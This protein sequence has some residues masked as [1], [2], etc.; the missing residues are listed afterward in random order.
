MSDDK[1]RQALAVNA[2]RKINAARRALMDNG[3]GMDAK[4]PASWCEFGYKDQLSFADY[5]QAYD[6]TALGFAAVDKRVN[7]VWSDYPWIIEGEPTD[8]DRK[9]S[10][11]EKRI[12]K[13]AKRA[14]L[15][16]SLKRAD[17]MRMIGGW[18]ALVLRI[19]DGNKLD[20]AVQTR[21]L[22][23]DSLIEV[24]PVYASQ[25]Q[26]LAN[27]QGQVTKYQYSKPGT[28]IE[29]ASITDIHPDRVII[30]GDPDNDRSLLRSGYNNL[31]DIEKVSGGSGE[32]F[33]KN[34]ARAIGINFDNDVEFEDIARMYGKKPEEMHEVLN[35]VARDMN[36][37]IDTVLATQGAQVQTLTSPVS[38][39]KPTFEVASQMF[40]ASVDTP[41]KILIGNVTGERAS[42]EDNA[43]WNVTCQAWRTNEASDL[44]K[45]V[46]DRL[47]DFGALTKLGEYSVMWTDLR[48]SSPTERAEY[49]DK[50]ADITQKFAAANQIADVMGQDTL[51]SLDELRVAMGYEREDEA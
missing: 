22:S 16:Q 26:A 7:K 32:S 39:P 18:S 38:D 27:D 3:G 12:G 8:D 47:V 4:R 43:S 50:L 13:M 17:E 14:K 23:P 49:A 28:N 42:T 21:A 48:E 25:I 24:T 19:A 35:D 44:V 40:A 5:Y 41:I 9:T 37:S 10:E 31:T 46:I 36:M 2:E 34:A 29:P 20:Q 6:R 33:L 11:I 30:V 45:S 15:W 51:V 1:F